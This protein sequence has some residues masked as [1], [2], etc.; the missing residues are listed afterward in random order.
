MP[1]ELK[2]AVS[3]KGPDTA[4]EEVEALLLA[5]EVVGLVVVGEVIEVETAGLEK[6]G[7][8]AE[9]TRSEGSHCE[10]EDLGQMGSITSQSKKI[11]TLYLPQE[12]NFK[13]ITLSLSCKSRSRS[14]NNRSKNKGEDL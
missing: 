14:S 9:A 13:A 7:A 6:P 5:L 10:P 11:K 12:N 1:A 8:E 2:S 4:T 3:E